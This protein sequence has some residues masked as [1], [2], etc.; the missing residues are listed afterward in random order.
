VGK[1]SLSRSQ[2]IP[3]D[4]VRWTVQDT[5]EAGT[6]GLVVRTYRQVE[7]GN[8]YPEEYDCVDVIFGTEY[9]DGWSFAHFA[10]LQ[11]NHA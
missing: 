5:P 4:L 9:W 8:N 11:R 3:G 2:L 6:Y 10:L 1:R 7:W